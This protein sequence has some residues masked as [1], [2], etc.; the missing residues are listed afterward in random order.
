MCV[1]SRSSFDFLFFFFWS[2]YCLFVFDIRLL[3]T[4]L[5]ICKRNVDITTYNLHLWNI[6]SSEMIRVAELFYRLEYVSYL[7][8]GYGRF[9][10]Y[11][12]GATII[13]KFAL[14]HPLSPEGV[15]EMTTTSGVWQRDDNYPQSGTLRWQ[16]PPEGDI[17]M[18]ITSRGWQWDDYYLQKV[19]LRWVLPPECDIKMNITSRGWY[20]AN[21][22]TIY[23]YE[24]LSVQKWYVWQ[25]FFTG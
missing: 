2:L 8:W 1:L 14:Y 20:K 13:I 16:L 18:T 4:P 12:S 19:T 6:I 22:I 21:L 17:E 10:T 5:V 25:N 11:M 3:I 23:T 7:F 9:T 15:I 24:I